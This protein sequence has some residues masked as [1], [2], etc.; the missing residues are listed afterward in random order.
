MG[1]TNIID[2]KEDEWRTTARNRWQ[3]IT[4][5]VVKKKTAI[6]WSHH[7]EHTH[8][9]LFYCSSGIC[10]ASPGWAGTRK[11]KPGSLKPI[12][13]YWSK[14][15][16]VAVVSAGLYASLHLIPDNHA[17]IPP[18][19]F[20]QAGSPSC[21]PT[22]S[23]KTLKAQHIMRK[24]GDNLEKDIIIG[25][26]HGN[27]SKGRPRHHW[28]D[29]AI[30]WQ[31]AA[32]SP[33]SETLEGHGS[34]CCRGSQWRI[35]HYHHHMWMKAVLDSFPIFTHSLPLTDFPALMNAAFQITAY[36]GLASDIWPSLP[37]FERL[38]DIR[39]LLERDLHLNP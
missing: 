8:T 35:R 38:A 5:L 18:L 1:A 30:T 12:W 9:Q 14:R 24:E 25:N 34:S 23:V 32:G 28:L 15:Q 39:N 29:R 2:S 20:L 27:R 37:S 36:G 4:G 6:L 26:T 10:P 31:V 13:I 11:V 19:R 17:N 16:W 3:T 22:N 33:G 21:H 7:E